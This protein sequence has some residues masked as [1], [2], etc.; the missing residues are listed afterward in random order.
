MRRS[1]GDGSLTRNA[2]PASSAASRARISAAKPDE[3]M[4]VKPRASTV[5]D[6]GCISSASLTCAQ[7]DSVPVHVELVHDNDRRS[8]V[9]MT[10]LDMQGLGPESFR[11]IRHR[12]SPAHGTPQVRHQSVAHHLHPL[13]GLGL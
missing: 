13:N 4:N 9:V 5:I 7:N 6:A 10:G 1:A 8:A 12:V 2:A 11:V 3:S